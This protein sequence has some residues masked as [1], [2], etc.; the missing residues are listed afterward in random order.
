MD[1]YQVYCA[2]AA[3]A[4]AIL[5]IAAILDTEALRD[6]QALAHE[7]GM[8]ALVE[9]HN[10]EE[11]ERALAAEPRIVGVNSRDL[12]TFEINLNT[13][14]ALRT[15]IPENIV[16]VAESGIHTP[17]DVARLNTIGVDAMLIGT[18][19]IKDEN[20]TQKVRDL[21]AAGKR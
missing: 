15:E 13:V 2:R 18:S 1:P 6:L 17:Q 14:E 19:L 3:G 4:D 11:L 9:V 8:V 20:R 16:L 5:L 12:H 10:R 7:L 21:V